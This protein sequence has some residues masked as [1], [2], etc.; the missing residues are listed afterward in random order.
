MSGIKLFRKS[1]GK[2]QEE[3]AAIIQVSKVNYSKKENGKVK[4]SLD[5]A[6]LISHYFEK[7]IEEIFGNGEIIISKNETMNNYINK[8]DESNEDMQISLF[9]D[10]KLEALS[11]PELL[12]PRK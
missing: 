7:S 11:N 3:F 12:V 4:F 8:N 10:E 5:E 1:I 9:E 6:Y 2:T